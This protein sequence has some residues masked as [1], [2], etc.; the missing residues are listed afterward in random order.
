MISNRDKMVPIQLC[1]K[2]F[3]LLS[4]WLVIAR[5][6]KAKKIKVIFKGEKNKEVESWNVSK[7]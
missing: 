1:L 6:G 5:S 4:A 7:L 3:I 2:E